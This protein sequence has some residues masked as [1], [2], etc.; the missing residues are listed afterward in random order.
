MNLMFSLRNCLKMSSKFEVSFQK[1]L[2][3]D[4]IFLREPAELSKEVT[5]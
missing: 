3:S 2:Y 4:H 5:T 1:N